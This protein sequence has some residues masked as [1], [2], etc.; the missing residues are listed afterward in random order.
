MF[1]DSHCHLDFPDFASELPDV[2]ARAHAAGV[3]RMITIS[4]RVAKYDVYRAIAE[5]QRRGLRDYYAS[6]PRVAALESG[7]FLGGVSAQLAGIQREIAAG[8]ATFRAILAERETRQDFM[9]SVG[10]SIDAYFDE[11][12]RIASR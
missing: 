6:P 11:E 12:L 7:N 8:E 9:D 1:I 10:D 5:A 4:T 2:I 3:G